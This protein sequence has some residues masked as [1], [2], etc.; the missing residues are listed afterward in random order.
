MRLLIGD[1]F[2]DALAQRAAAHRCVRI[3]MLEQL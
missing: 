2:L 1:N 3:K